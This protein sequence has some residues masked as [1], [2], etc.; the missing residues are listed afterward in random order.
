MAATLCKSAIYMHRHIIYFSCTLR[1]KKSYA[2]KWNIVIV[3]TTS[4][5]CGK[6]GPPCGSLFPSN[7]MQSKTNLQIRSTISRCS[8]MGAEAT[9]R[10]KHKTT[11]VRFKTN[12]RGLK[13]SDT[14][15]QDANKIRIHVHE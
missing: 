3:Q 11:C 4:V 2:M 13:L 9:G 5:L 1:D 15:S 12:S 14:V 10:S 6:H 8:D 7:S